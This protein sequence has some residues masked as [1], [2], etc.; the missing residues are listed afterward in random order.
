MAVEFTDE[1][2]ERVQL[3]I[4]MITDGQEDINRAKMAG[5][6]VDDREKALHQKRDQLLAIKQAF[7]AGG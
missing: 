4:D 1:E 5:L 7:F 6:D 2:K 3:A